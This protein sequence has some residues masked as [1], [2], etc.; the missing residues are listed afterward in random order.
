MMWWWDVLRGRSYAR[1][2]RTGL[3]I[4]IIVGEKGKITA[5]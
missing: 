4:L 5:K 3:L 2:W 1:D